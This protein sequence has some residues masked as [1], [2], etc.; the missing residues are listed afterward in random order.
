MNRAHGGI[1]LT[2]M[3]VAMALTFGLGLIE[4]MTST[5]GVDWDPDAAKIFSVRTQQLDDGELKV[6]VTVQLHLD[7]V[8]MYARQD[9]DQMYNHHIH[10]APIRLQSDCNYSDRRQVLATQFPALTPGK[11]RLNIMLPNGDGHV[12]FLEVAPPAPL[13]QGLRLGSL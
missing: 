8:R 13:D 4:V 11:H 12:L 6:E 1:K 5:N 7:C 2:T 10:I 3:F 9:G